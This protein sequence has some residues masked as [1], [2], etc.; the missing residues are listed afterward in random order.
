MFNVQT[1]TFFHSCVSSYSCGF[2]IQSE[3]D[4]AIT[5]HD[6]NKRS[7]KCGT[8]KAKHQSKNHRTAGNFKLILH[9]ELNPYG[10]QT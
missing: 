3:E 10:L 8:E 9:R 6:G 5:E 2:A 4:T 1:Y 7:L